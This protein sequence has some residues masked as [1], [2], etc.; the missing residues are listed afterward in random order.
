MTSIRI[1]NG[2]FKKFLKTKATY[3]HAKFKIYRNKLNHLIKLAK[4]NYYNKFFSVHEN[5]GKRI[6]YGI[7]QI[8]QVKTHVN[9]HVN[10][11]VV[12]NREI[13]DQESIANALNEFFANI[14]SNLASSFLMLLKLPE[15]SCHL[16]FVIACFCLQS[17]SIKQ[18]KYKYLL[19]F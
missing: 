19:K 4:R 13:V 7:E 10:K 9:Q 11:I 14:G 3:Y 5:N 8:V 2:L 16:P 18:N 17:V 12:D 1:K 6:W 15:S